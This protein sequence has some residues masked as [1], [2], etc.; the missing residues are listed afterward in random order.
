MNNR[1]R[2]MLSLAAG[3]IVFTYISIMSFMAIKDL[4]RDYQAMKNVDLS[5]SSR[6]SIGYDDHIYT[7]TGFGI[8]I[9]PADSNMSATLND[10]IESSLRTIDRRIISC[11]IL[12]TMIVV[13]VLAYFL[14]QV[15]GIEAKKHTLRV[16][17]YVPVVF[18]SFLALIVGFHIIQ[19][20]PFYF[21][22][23]Y[24][25]LQILVSLSAVIGGSCCLA[26]ILR[27]VRWKRAVSLI[28]IPAVLFLFIFSSATEGRLY[29]PRTV[30]SFDYVAQEYE[31][32]LYDDDFEGEAYYDEDKNVLFVNGKEYPPQETE[33]PDYLK[34]AGRAGAILFEA[35]NP[36]AASGLFMVCEA[37]DLNVAMSNL[38]LYAFKS[39]TLMA[40]TA[41]RKEREQ[42]R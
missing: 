2:G 17:I 21:P 24:D 19:S 13:T 1:M 34:G 27:V 23:R 4:S 40:L 16:I 15:F 39:V 31:P 14:H 37:A 42:S 25:C 3:I 12:Y 18:V 22:K 7:S 20:V 9:D 33:N 29:S 26:W 38:L 28:A 41:Y 35:I 10:Y 30:Y 36:Y 6:V 5:E 11:L 8:E 32:N